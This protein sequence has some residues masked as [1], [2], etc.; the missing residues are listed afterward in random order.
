MVTLEWSSNYQTGNSE[1]DAQHQIFVKIIN[2]LI[3]AKNNDGDKRF[4]ESLCSELLKY[5]E[6]HF[7]SEENIMIEHNYPQYIEHRKHHEKVLSELRNR[8]FSLQYDYID[9]ANLESFITDWFTNHTLAEDMKLA[10][11]LAKIK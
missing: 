6:F 9:F 5:A 10:K 3:E 8:L 1:I 4:I 2:K 11:F 7:C